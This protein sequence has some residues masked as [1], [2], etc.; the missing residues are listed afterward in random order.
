MDTITESIK[1]YKIT[2]KKEMR[3]VYDIGFALPTEKIAKTQSALEKEIRE[4]FISNSVQPHLARVCKD[5]SNIEKQQYLKEKFNVESFKDLIN[6]SMSN[7]R[8]GLR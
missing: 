3:S 1:G 2:R 5:M 4:N 8:L 6:L 7:L